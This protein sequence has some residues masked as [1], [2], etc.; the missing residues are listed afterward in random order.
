MVER[1]TAD[2]CKRNDRLEGPDVASCKPGTKVDLFPATTTYI[3]ATVVDPSAKHWDATA[4]RY[5]T[6]PLTSHAFLQFVGRHPDLNK[7]GVD[8]YIDILTQRSKDT[9]RDGVPD[10]VQ[11]KR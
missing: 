9:N 7:N 1:I 11:K 3:T 8:D 10:E 4:K 5:V 6:G 2:D